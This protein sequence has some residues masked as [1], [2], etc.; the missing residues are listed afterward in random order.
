MSR[1]DALSRP[2]IV[3]AAIELLDV[4]GEAGLTFRTLATRLET[5]PGA[6]YWHIANKDELLAAATDDVITDAL[7]LVAAKRAPGPMI[8]AVALRLFDTL[9]VH[10]WAGT[11]LSRAASQT[12]MLQIYERFGVQLQALRVPTQTLFFAASALVN[13]VLGVA[14]QNAALA[15]QAVDDRA[16]HLARVAAAWSA[17]APE[18]H[19]F[20]H[21]MAAQLRDHDDR[22]QFVAG[23]DLILAGIAASGKAQR[24]RPSD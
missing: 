1:P 18:A 16:G 23:I 21:Q 11:Q 5:G 2:R 14:S 7:A 6:I 8:R 4:E 19:P 15:R 20:I 10:P 3:Q 17:V 13:Y 9:E 22:A 24:R 12:A